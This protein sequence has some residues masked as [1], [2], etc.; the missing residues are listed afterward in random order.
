MNTSTPNF[1]QPLKR[2]DIQE[3]I[4]MNKRDHG[5]TL[6]TLREKLAD[7]LA[8]HRRHILLLKY[9][10]SRK[11]LAWAFL[12]YQRHLKVLLPFE[13]QAQNLTEQIEYINQTILEEKGKTECQPV[14]PAQ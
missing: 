3:K 14:I 7:E 5:Y 12:T 6:G 13:V 2:E 9:K 4:E 1:F 11:N 10:H 8:Q